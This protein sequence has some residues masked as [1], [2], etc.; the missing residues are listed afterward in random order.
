LKNNRINELLNILEEVDGKVIIWAVYR[1]DIKEITNVLS[2]RYGK[3]SVESFFGD[4]ADSDRQD[5]VSRFQ[6]RESSLR[7]F[8]GNPR[9]GGYGLTLTASNTVVYYSNSYDLEIRLQS[10]DR[11]HRISQTKK[12][13]YIDLIS[14]GTID[15]FIVKNLRGKINLATKVLGE[16]LKKWLI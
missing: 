11:A 12:V 9:T 13:T 3:D 16:E 4:T 2:E 1:H 10:E 7:F 15:E 8:V 14:D 5:I 6:D